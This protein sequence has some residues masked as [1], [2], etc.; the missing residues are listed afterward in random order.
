MRLVTSQVF[1]DPSAW[2]HI[3][4]NIDTTQVTSSNRAKIY[5]NGSQVTSFSTE[6][7]MAQ[8]SDTSVNMVSRIIGLAGQ[9]VVIIFRAT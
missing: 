7:Y 8:N 2:Y 3:L 4:C 1:R 5:V 9:T 6:T